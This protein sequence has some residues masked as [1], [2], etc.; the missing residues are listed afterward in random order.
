MTE[1]KK[2]KTITWGKRLILVLIIMGGVFYG[3]LNLAE[4]SKDSIRLGL[5]D[6]LSQSTGQKAIIT[7]MPT[8]ELSPDM[9]FRMN[10]IV[11]GDVQDNE[12]TLV[13]VQ[14]AYISMPF[15]R[16][17]LGMQK[18][19]GF[20]IQNMD[21]ASGFLLPQKITINF[22]GITDA[23]PATTPP[24]FLIDGTYNKKPVL[25]TFGLKRQKAKN[26]YLYS[27]PS[28]SSF[29]VKIGNLESNGFL[30]RGFSDLDFKEVKLAIN[31][32]SANFTITGFKQNPLSGFIDGSINDIPITGKLL[33]RDN[34]FIVSLNVQSENPNDFNS[35]QDFIDAIYDELGIKDDDK[36]Q[37]KIEN[38]KSKEE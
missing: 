9:V 15:W 23:D 1:H 3:V 34:R 18:Y 17:V 36:F 28:L 6:Y 21:I 31:Q 35:I 12:K 10:G 20:E 25:M 11:I 30:S 4:R 24:S 37:I 14:K 27:I 29:T 5:Q 32:N 22:A 7:D 26:Y 19:I 16:M 33:S 13:S 8:V 2:S 38:E